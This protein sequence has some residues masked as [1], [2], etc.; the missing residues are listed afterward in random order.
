MERAA[1][2]TSRLQPLPSTSPPEDDVGRY[3]R[4]AVSYT[5]G[6][7]NTQSAEAITTD[8]VE[9]ERSGV[10]CPWCEPEPIWTATPSAHGKA[11]RH[12][13]ARADRH[14]KARADRHTKA[15]ADR[16]TETRADCHTE[17]R[18]DCHTETHSNR[19]PNGD[20]VP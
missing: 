11:D 5:D 2:R 8:Q 18:A 16:H 7:G 1:G 3:L 4:A 19:D 9:R 15:R 17:T 13:K 20:S 14:T 6:D 10:R 12:T